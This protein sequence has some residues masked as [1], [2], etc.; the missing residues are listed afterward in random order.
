ML[1]HLEYLLHIAAW[2]YTSGGFT[3]DLTSSELTFSQYKA[4][5]SGRGGDRGGWGSNVGGG[6]RRSGAG[7]GRGGSGGGR[8]GSSGSG[9]GMK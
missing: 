1:A 8:G 4:T 3:Y 9:A 5:C 7:G 6:G 2:I